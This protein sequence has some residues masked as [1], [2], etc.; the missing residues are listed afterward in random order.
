MEQHR[1]KQSCNGKNFK[2]IDGKRKV[3]MRRLQNYFWF[4]SQRLREGIV[5][6]SYDTL[7]GEGK[8]KSSCWCYIRE[9]GGGGGG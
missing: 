5:Q 9:G 7:K 1:G 6:I 8:A 2:L 3:E 4:S